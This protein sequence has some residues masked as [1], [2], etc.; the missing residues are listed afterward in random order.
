MEQFFSPLENSDQ[1][2]GG[3]RSGLHQGLQIWKG[4]QPLRPSF[5]SLA[6][7][8]ISNSRPFVKKRNL[9]SAAFQVERSFSFVSTTKNTAGFSR[10]GSYWQLTTDHWQPRP[11]WNG[12]LASVE[13]PALAAEGTWDNFHRG[14]Q[15]TRFWFAGVGAGAQGRASLFTSSRALVLAVR[16][17]CILSRL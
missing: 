4:L 6:E 9:A 8:C 15:Q 14:P 2:G 11:S 3:G 7:S 12:V 16:A 5:S 17:A 13:Y 1:Q 10:C